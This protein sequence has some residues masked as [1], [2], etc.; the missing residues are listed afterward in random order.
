MNKVGYLL[1]KEWLEHRRD[2]Q[3]ILGTLIP[4]VLFAIMPIVVAGVIGSAPPGEIATSGRTSL[5]AGVNPALVGMTVQEVAQTLICQQ[6]SLLFFLMPMI[7]PSVIASYSIVGEKTRRTL[8]PLLATPVRTWELLLAKCLTA[9]IPALVITWLSGL[10]FIGGMRAVAVSSRVFSAVISPGWLLILALCT[11]LMALIVIA[12][13]VAISARVNDPR[14]AQQLS[15]FVLLPSIAAFFGQLFGLLVLSPSLVF[16]VTTILAA[17]AAL[18]IWVASR[19]FQREIV[20]TRW[21]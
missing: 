11:P 8:E 19:L 12:L 2:R 18:A 13:M 7:V 3:I 1:E 15:T 10:I 14:T 21:R 17:T 4:P 6:F 16:L 9:L 20:L 5:G